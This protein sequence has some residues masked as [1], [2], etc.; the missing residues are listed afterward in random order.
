MS[1]HT[2][3]LTLP[4]GENALLRQLI[5]QNMQQLPEL[6]RKSTN[7]KDRYVHIANEN[8]AY[9]KDYFINCAV[10]QVPL[11]SGGVCFFLG[12]EWTDLKTTQE[13]LL[14]NGLKALLN[15]AFLI[16]FDGEAI[17]P[18]SKI[19]DVIKKAVAEGLTPPLYA[20]MCEI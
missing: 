14:K 3:T 2:F 9:S 4:N 13:Y 7:D 10:L 20:L 6:F 15:R 18:F 1:K 8:L 19:G 5:G 16:A 17:S 11:E 12:S